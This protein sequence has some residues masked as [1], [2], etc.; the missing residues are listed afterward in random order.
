MSLS[1]QDST[2]SDE[3]PTGYV[4]FSGTIFETFAG[5][6]FTILNDRFLIFIYVHDRMYAKWKILSVTEHCLEEMQI[7][8]Y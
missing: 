5:F 4:D 8:V 7:Y 3:F 6:L 2:Q 1:R